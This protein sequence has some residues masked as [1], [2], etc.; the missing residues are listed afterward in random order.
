MSNEDEYLNNFVE[1]PFSKEYFVEAFSRLDSLLDRLVFQILDKNFE[2]TKNNLLFKLFH[3]GAIVPSKVAKLLADEELIDSK[4]IKLIEE[5]KSFRNVL[6]HNS[7]GQFEVVLKESGFYKKKHVCANCEGCI[8]EHL[9]KIGQP[10][11]KHYSIDI[12]R[13]KLDLGLSAYNLLKSNLKSIS[14]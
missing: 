4:V 2:F 9:S 3:K 8:N 7:Q 5:F 12:L 6:V 1:E 13:K 11:I 14:H 10:C